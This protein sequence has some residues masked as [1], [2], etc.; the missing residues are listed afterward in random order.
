MEMFLIA[1]IIALALGLVWTYRKGFQDGFKIG[2]LKDKAEPVAVER[3][4]NGPKKTQP[5]KIPEELKRL[6]TLKQNIDAYDGTERGQ[7]DVK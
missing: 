5:S 2:N 4:F 7:V 6:Q 1:V 3:A